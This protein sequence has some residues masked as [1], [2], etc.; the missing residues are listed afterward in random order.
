MHIYIPVPKLKI[1]TYNHYFNACSILK[2]LRFRQNARML[3]APATVA[4]LALVAA[5]VQALPAVQDLEHAG[6]AWHPDLVGAQHVSDGL[7]L[8]QVLGHVFAQTSSLMLNLIAVGNIAVGE[9]HDVAIFESGGRT[10]DVVASASGGS[11]L[12]EVVGGI[13]Q[14]IDAAGLY[15]ITAAGSIATTT[16]VTHLW[17]QQNTAAADFI[18][19]EYGQITVLNPQSYPVV[20]GDWMIEFRTHGIHDL[21]V[22]AIESTTFG[23]YAPDD[24]GFVDLWC[25]S[26]SIRDATARNG[27]ITFEDYQCHGISSLVLRVHTPGIHDLQFSFGAGMAYASNNAYPRSAVEINDS[28]IN[29]PTLSNSDSFGISAAGIGDLDGDGVPDLAVGADDD[30]NGGTDRGAVHVMLM[31]RDGTVKGTIE[32]NSST[33]DGP[34]LSNSDYFGASV[35]GIGDLDGDG[36]PDLAAGAWADDNGGVNRG[37]VHVMFMNGNGTVK[38]TVEINNGTPNGPTLSDYDFFGKSAAGIGDLDGDGV[39]DLAAGAWGDDGNGGTDRG[40]VHVMFM[41]RDGTVKGTAEIS[42]GTANGPTLSDNDFFGTSVAAI[43][44]LDGDGVPDLAA[45]AWRDDGN[46]G[47]DRGAVHVMLMNRDGTVNATIEINDSTTDGPELSNLDHFGVSVA[48]IGDLD[49]D[50]VPDLAAGA[51]GDDEG[52]TN[53]GAVHVMLMNR[54][55]TVKGTIEINDSTTDGPELSDGDFFGASV[56]GIGDLDGDGVPNL[57]VGADGDDNG[58]PSRGAVHIIRIND[59]KTNGNGSV[60]STVEINSDTLNGPTLSLNDSFGISA[61]GIGDLDGDGV[62]DLAVGADDDDNGGTDRG[63]VHVMFMNRDGTVKGTVEI[64]SSTTNGPTLSDSDYFGASVAGIDDL[65]GDGVPD[66]AA[67]AWGDDN[68]GNNRGAVHVMFMNRDGTVKGTVE[69]N[70]STTNGPTLSNDDSFGGSVAGI[71]DLDGDGVPDLAAGAWGDD[72]NGGTDRGAVHVMFMNRDGTVKGTIEINSSTTNGPTLSNNDFFGKSVAAI[73]DL[74][75]DGVPDLAVGADEDDNGGTGRGAV[76][77]MFMNGDG[78]VKD[79]IEINSSTTNGPTLSNLDNFGISVAG[80]GDLDGDGVPDLAAGAWSDDNGGTDRGAVHVMFMN[81]NGTVKATIEINDSTTDGPTL[82]NNDYFGASV[83]GIGD[84]DGDGVPDLAVGADGDNNGGDNRGTVHV[85]YLDKDV[86]VRA[87]SSTTA[88]GRYGLGQIVNITVKFS[89]SV[90]V[91][92]T[93]RLTLDVSPQ[94]RTAPYLTGNGTDTLTFRYAPQSTDES[95]DLQYVA[96]NSLSPDGGTITALES[97]SKE[98]ILLLPDPVVRFDFNPPGAFGSLAQNKDI[99]IYMIPSSSFVTTWQTTGANETITIPGTGTYTVDWGD[100]SMPTSENGTATHMYA[101]NGTYTVSISGGLTRI[102]LGFGG[103]ENSEKLQ[104]I[105]QWGNMTWSSMKSAFEGASDMTYSATDAPDLSGVIDMS[106]MFVEASSFD[107]NLSAWNVSTVTRMESMFSKAAAFDGDVSTW[108]VSKVT[109]MSYMFAGSPFNR[110]LSTWDVSSVTNMESMFDA[111]ESFDRP[112]N[113]WNVSSV[114]N[115]ADMFLGASDFNQPLNGWN[116]SSVTS[117][118]G[119]FDTAESFNQ[120]LSTWDVSGV[121]DMSSMFAYGPFNQPISTWN[122]SKV[123]DMSGMFEAAT[124]FNQPIS[125]WN[126][127]GVTDMLEMFLDADAFDQNLGKWYV[128]PDSTSIIPSDVPGI[129]G[130]ISAQNSILGG[131]VSTYGIGTGGDMARFEIVND[132]KLNMTSAVTGRNSYTANVTATGDDVFGNDNT[133]RTIEVTLDSTSFATTWRTDSA[134]QAITVPVT[135]SNLTISWGDGTTSAGV[136]GAQTHTYAAAGNH[137]V[138]V[139]G[140][141]EAF[142]LNNHANATKLVSIDQWSNAS[143]TTMKDAFRGANNMVYNAADSPDLSGVTDMNSMFQSSSING[144]I[145]GWDV[146]GVTDMSSMF[147]DAFAFN[148]NVSGWD[149]SGVTDMSRMFSGAPL[150]NGDVSGWDVSAV[151]DMN[152]MFFL[153]EAFNQNLNDWD[154]S[155]VTNMLRMF[156]GASLFNGDVPSRTWT[157]C[158]SSPRPS[159]RISTTGTSRASPTC[160]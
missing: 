116:V 51:S 57:A 89:E 24:V 114:T 69:I 3:A 136:S 32:I 53:S 75:G 131:H 46:G 56:A 29:G 142:T 59:M 120:D 113:G 115:M 126:V 147:N 132:N 86:L 138:A 41:N 71:G 109:D 33:T 50:G 60:D 17:A 85:M 110:T 129:V 22:S 55:G 130:E 64:N 40:A 119:M 2:V 108:D 105:D 44:D 88:D 118:N 73:G 153:A 127:S 18:I 54:D 144:D 49:G 99:E 78:T 102:N 74:D 121:T 124:K 39:P 11:G 145:S 35:A 61:A 77:V 25:G 107:G 82:S 27:V 42:N 26:D 135:G 134:S 4:V 21:A 37:A 106:N 97:P 7:P 160:L 98:A 148:G 34:E 48:G 20:G 128:V 81:G 143:W 13:D 155:A 156:S 5:S 146:S 159:T 112:L 43:G 30:D 101:T 36:V 149:V 63:A 91:T 123:T 104:S 94:H 6:P 9:A 80:I 58:G 67:G 95:L 96:E 133:W 141:L 45:G 72:G 14:I 103:L 8:D 92:G 70:N 10:Y 100:G 15:K 154:V 65:D 150:F 12:V 111:A 83:A 152:R 137:T 19:Q 62:P 68:G 125:T 93:P 47:T 122:V 66:L 79:T 158:S 52:G 117:M 90:A 1:M 28:T 23:D 31:N 140:G 38:S 84:L 157:A 76:H 151:Q 87:V 139:T 16:T